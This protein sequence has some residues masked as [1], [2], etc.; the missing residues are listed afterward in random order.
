MPTL[1]PGVPAMIFL[2]S[3]FPLRS[4]PDRIANVLTLYK[5]FINP[6]YLDLLQPDSAHYSSLQIEN[7]FSYS[8]PLFCAQY[9][10]FSFELP[11]VPPLYIRLTQ[12]SFRLNGEVV[13]H[14]ASPC[15]VCYLAIE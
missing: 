13:L 10:V 3:Y 6:Q 9:L 11:D 7:H 8:F 1:P 5:N 4:L 14:S 2:S 15:S 12:T